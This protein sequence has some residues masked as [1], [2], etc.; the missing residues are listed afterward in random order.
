MAKN[1]RQGCQIC[2]LRVQTNFLGF[3][4]KNSNLHA[5]SFKKRECNWQTLGKKNACFELMIFLPCVRYGRKIVKLR[6]SCRPPTMAKVRELFFELCKIFLGCLE[7]GRVSKG[8]SV[9]GSFECLVL[10][11]TKSFFPSKS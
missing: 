9:E 2:I 7:S 1:F 5:T 3:S 6:G 10:F 11:A 8:G 4:K